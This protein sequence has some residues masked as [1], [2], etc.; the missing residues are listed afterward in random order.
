VNF[1][2]KAGEYWTIRQQTKSRSVKSRTGQL[3]DLSTRRQQFLNS[4]KIVG[5]I[6]LVH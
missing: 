6:I 1:Y 2:K 5:L 3:A 4:G